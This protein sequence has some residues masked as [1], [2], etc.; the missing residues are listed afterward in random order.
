MHWEGV[1]SISVSTL[2][3]NVTLI[4]HSPLIFLLHITRILLLR[5][6]WGIVLILDF[7]QVFIIGLILKFSFPNFIFILFFSNFCF[8]FFLV[9]EAVILLVGISFIPTARVTSVLDTLIYDG[10][11]MSLGLSEHVH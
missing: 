2:G 1:A 3:V 9:S 11:D 4:S 5:D 10:V 8:V 7:D 6:Y